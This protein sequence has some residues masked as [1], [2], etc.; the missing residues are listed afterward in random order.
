MNEAIDVVLVDDQDLIRT[1]FSLVLGSDPTIR[2]VAEAR[3]GQE[4]VDTVRELS[5]AGQTPDVV[6]MDIRMPVMDGIQAT[7]EIVAEFPEISVLVLTT[8]DIDEYAIEAVDAGASGFLLKDMRADELLRA[9]HAVCGG[10]AVIVPS[11]AMRLVAQLARASARSVS[12]PT[13]A[14]RCWRCSPNASVR[15]LRRSPMACR[16]PRSGRSCSFR[17]RR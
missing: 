9:V 5:A 6:L 1:G 4:A 3:N 11:V 7:R 12:Y 8:F 2:V 17:S 16:M 14:P 13:E 10:D 15:C